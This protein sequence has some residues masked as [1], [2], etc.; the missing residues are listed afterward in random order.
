MFK[1]TTQ[2]MQQ[3]KASLNESA[4]AQQAVFDAIGFN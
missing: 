2:Q 4:S 3:L 1:V